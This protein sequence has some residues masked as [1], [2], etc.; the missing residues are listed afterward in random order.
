VSH[1][2]GPGGTR[3]VAI[4]Y[5]AAS[6]LSN[7]LG[8]AFLVVL[9]RGLDPDEFGELGSLLGLGML[10]SV[11][12]VAIQL[13]VARRT[14]AARAGRHTGVM[15]RRFVLVLSTGVALSTLAATPLAVHYL[16]LGSAWPA[17]WVALTLLP[18][19]FVGSL[20]GELL[21]EER[22]R[23]L[24]AAIVAMATLRLASGLLA[25]AMGWD[26]S[27]CTAALAVATFVGTFIVSR[28]TSPPDADAT[29]VSWQ[30]QMRE[31][32]QTTQRV[33]AFLVLSNLDV[34]LA[35]H[36]LS[37]PES[38]LYVLGSLFAKAGLWGPQFV[39]VL[40]Y[41]RLSSGRERRA[42]FI[43]AA[44]STAALGGLIAVGTLV[45]ADPVIRGFSGAEYAA[46]ARVAPWFAL[47][48]T[49]LALVH[50]CMVT[51]VAV[52]ERAYGAVI[53]L[54][55][56]AELVVVSLGRH[57][58]ISEIVGACLIVG[59]AL[60]VAGAVVLAVHRIAGLRG[61]PRA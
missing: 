1:A 21:G 53:W 50:L 40:A 49:T 35:R 36:Y 59:A 4:L 56:A 3:V 31:T 19:T 57:G 6:L 14:A 47:L 55:V 26:V 54:A 18:M 27:G 42:T 28:L 45:I 7:A 2:R 44:V 12:S 10:A 25:V 8:Y 30:A 16:R 15:S 39:A 9:S 24:A 29:R 13:V 23:R 51:T 41:P 22:F 32:W 37:G 52:G 5:G 43:R 38:G 33:G 17:I 58:S 20:T 48:G 11:L 61:A 34:L 46:A 60:V